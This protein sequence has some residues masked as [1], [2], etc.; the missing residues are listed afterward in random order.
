[1]GKFNQYIEA[2]INERMEGGT[3]TPT[4]SS[5]ILTKGAGQSGTVAETYDLELVDKNI[6][7]MINGKN[8]G[9]VSIDEF[10]K[11]YPDIAKQV[12]EVL[13]RDGAARYA[14][15]MQPPSDFVKN[16]RTSGKLVATPD[17]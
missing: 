4:T 11:Q 3:P 7:G 15:D 2:A 5:N 9:T 10:S 8:I 17:A 13:K 14:P 16:P 1:M 12:L 6:R